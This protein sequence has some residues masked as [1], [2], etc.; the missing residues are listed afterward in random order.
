MKKDQR[1]KKKLG[2]G[3]VC[4]VLKKYLHPQSLVRD[5][6][7]WEKIGLSERVEGLLV[8]GREEKESGR[9]S[10]RSAKD[11]IIFRHDDHPNRQIFC[12][13]D[14]FVHCYIDGGAEN[15]FK[16]RENDTP[17]M[18]AT[19]EAPPSISTPELA[20]K[21]HVA[22]LVQGQSCNLD[23]TDIAQFRAMGVTVDDDNDPAPENIPDVG[24]GD[25]VPNQE[26]PDSSRS[27]PSGLIQSHNQQWGHHLVDQRKASVQTNVN[28]S[29]P[30]IPSA[31]R[32]NGF[33]NLSFGY[34]FILFLGK[35]ML[36]NLIIEATN[37][38]LV[39]D[40][41]RKLTYGEFLRWIGIWLF[42]STTSGCA[43][44]EYWSTSAPTLEGSGTP[45]RFNHWMSRTRFEVIL[46]YLCF[47][48]SSNQPTFVDKF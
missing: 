29:V 43:R 21:E 31:V 2:I 37:A 12:V 4:S 38:R 8:V 47:A 24:N 30:G 18:S 3:G 42:I 36:Q 20:T 25:K 13:N 48:P 34:I 44:R 45:Y 10:S 22:E 33:E 5:C 17:A 16:A 11:A 7:A 14:R 28:P 26:S 9:G 27:S 46:R 15:H 41:C 40:G 39:E 1:P 19:T 32:E 35:A 6:K 23:A